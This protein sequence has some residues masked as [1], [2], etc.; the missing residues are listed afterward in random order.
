[1]KLQHLFASIVFGAVIAGA[2]SPALALASND[3]NA[4]VVL[5][6]AAPDAKAPAEG[7]QKERV[8]TEPFYRLEV[9]KPLG[10]SAAEG[11]P[12]KD[13]GIWMEMRRVDEERSQCDIRI[14]TWL[15]KTLEAGESVDDFTR[16]AV[17]RF[18]KNHIDT[19][20][21]KAP[22]RAPWP[23]AHAAYKLKLAGRTK[24]GITVQEDCRIVDHENGRI[25]EFQVTMYGG[26]SRSFQKEIAAFWK[27]LEITSK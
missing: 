5:A 27:K 22:P 16:K 4:P 13:P 8:L 18:E 14:R 20:V 17:E 2:V 19:R 11:D 6:Q 3:G 23:G 24:N 21:P 7:E 15:K 1:M 26:A 12:N 10:F 25:Y 9:L